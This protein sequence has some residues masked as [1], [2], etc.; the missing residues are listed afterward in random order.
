VAAAFIVGLWPAELRPKEGGR[1]RIHR[2][3]EAAR[4]ETKRGCFDAL[5]SRCRTLKK[6]DI[7]LLFFLLINLPQ[8]VAAPL[9]LPRRQ[10]PKIV[11]G[12]H[13]VVFGLLLT[14][15]RLIFVVLI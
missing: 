2:R 9:I 8:N 15:F 5:K 6:E 13:H 10:P 7:A 14:V 1:C 12:P 11:N 4:F 3:A